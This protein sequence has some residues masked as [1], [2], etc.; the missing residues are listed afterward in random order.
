MTRDFHGIIACLV[1]LDFN[2]FIFIANVQ[3]V[4][5][6]LFICDDIRADRC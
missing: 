3:F 2:S 4:W 6:P 1:C 5:P